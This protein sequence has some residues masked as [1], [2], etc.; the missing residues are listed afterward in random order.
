MPK[1]R[2]TIPDGWRPTVG[3]LLYKH[4]KK[5]RLCV[6]VS[7]DVDGTWMV[8]AVET[9]GTTVNAILDD[10]AHDFV[11]RFAFGKAIAVAERYAAAW[12]PGHKPT[13]ACDDIGGA[14]KPAKRRKL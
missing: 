14:A 1:K 7:Q 11:G 10:H 6:G 2:L 13:C 12:K 5:V 8:L 9:K 3:L 4:V